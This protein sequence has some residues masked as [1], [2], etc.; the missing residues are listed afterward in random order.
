ML[1][2][3]N[4]VKLKSQCSNIAPSSEISDIIIFEKSLSF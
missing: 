1:T 2:L 4:L 3:S